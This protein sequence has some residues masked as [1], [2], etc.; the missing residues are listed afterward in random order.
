MQ[1]LISTAAGAPPMARVVARTLERVARDPSAGSAMAALSGRFALRSAKDSQA[2]TIRFDHGSIEIAGGVDTDAGVVVTLDLDTMG[3]PGAPR[4]KVKGLA[5]H[6]FL[7]YKVGKLLDAKS[8]ESWQDVVQ[9]FWDRTSG[10]A[11]RP[12][13]LVVACEEDGTS[14]RLGGP[15]APVMEIL[16]GTATLLSVFGGE[17]DPAQEWLEGR[18]RVLASQEALQRFEGLARSVMLA[19]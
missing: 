6:P 17:A 16:A 8:T 4:P 5:R 13:P 15:D 19:P 14:I 1:P 9:R 11:G 2:I 18:L 3:Q 7:A 10:L 12:D